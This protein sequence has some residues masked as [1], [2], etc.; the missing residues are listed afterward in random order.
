[1]TQSVAIPFPRRSVGTSYIYVAIEGVG[2]MVYAAK[3]AHCAGPVSAVEYK[4]DG[5]GGGG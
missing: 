5:R 3:T 1:M 4:L 2:K